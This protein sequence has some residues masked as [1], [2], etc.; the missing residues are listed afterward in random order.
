MFFFVD[1]FW[2]FIKDKKLLELCRCSFTIAYMFLQWNL[3]N[4]NPEKSLSGMCACLLQHP[5][6][7]IF[8]SR[9]HDRQS[10]DQNF[11][12]RG[13]DNYDCGRQYAFKVI[14]QQFWVKKFFPW[15][16]N[17]EYGGTFTKL[18][19]IFSS[20]GHD[21][22]S[23]DQNFSSRGHDW[24]SSEQNNQKL[25]SLH[26]NGEDDKHAHVYHGLFMLSY[27]WVVVFILLEL[28][29]ISLLK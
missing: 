23:S 20:R 8:S 7:F 12:S 10:S 22:Q 15:K 28:L 14:L 21:R 17:L 6:L 16:F 4:P 24:Q 27:L 2:L 26:N 18:V 9:G 11:S 1:P 3:S 13:H 25:I 19:M 5:W 29:T